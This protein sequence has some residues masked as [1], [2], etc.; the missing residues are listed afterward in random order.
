MQDDGEGV[1]AA[2]GAS[3]CIE[4]GMADTRV[5]LVTGAARRIGAAIAETLHADGW[6]VVVHAHTSIDA[7]RALVAGLNARRADSAEA[8]AADLRDVTAIEPLALAARQRWQ[9]LDALVNNASSYFRTPLGSISA[10]QI[11]ELTA[12]NLRAPL[13][14]TQACV[15]LMGDGGA[16]VNIVDALLR[17]PMP[18]FLPYY[19]AK[20]GLASLTETLALE[21]APGIRVNGVAPGHM[22]WATS[23]ALSEDQQ[24]AE[25]ARV[26]LARLGGAGEIAHAVRY[27]LSP[28]AAYVTGALLPVDGGLRLR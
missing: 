7:A 17:K 1:R 15:P 6:N 12:S 20:A 8:L 27:L 4:Y 3:G 21:L 10:A 16:I 22:L 18:G 25:L 9:R 19:A 11:D 26:P 23:S 24:D 13:L 14:L 28:A 5:V 2:R